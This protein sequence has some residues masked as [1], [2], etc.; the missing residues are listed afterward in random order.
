MSALF[1]AIEEL[2]RAREQVDQQQQKYDAAM[3]RAMEGDPPRG[4]PPVSPPR[5][6][7]PATRSSKAIQ[8]H[9]ERNKTNQGR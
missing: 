4:R 1:E 3:A 9:Q 2:T 7:S 8:R 5:W 6:A